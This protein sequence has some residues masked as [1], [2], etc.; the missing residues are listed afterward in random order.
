MHVRIKENVYAIPPKD[1]MLFED[2]H[3]SI[4]RFYREQLFRGDEGYYRKALE[5][6]YEKEIR[7]SI[8]K[9]YE[10]ID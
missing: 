1:E 7:E 8:K 6:V 3:F 2:G 10:I 4:P 9:P 5:E